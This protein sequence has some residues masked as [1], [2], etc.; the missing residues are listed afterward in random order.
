MSVAK[1]T[2]SAKK[3]SVK[4]PQ[5]SKKAPKGTA[6]RVER[7]LKAVVTK[8]SA[9]PQKI[10][11]PLSKSELAEFRTMLLNKRRSLVGDMNGMQNEALRVNRQDGSGDLSL[12][13]D[14]PANIASDT[15]E[16]EFTLGLLES[17]RTLLN[18]ID[19]ALRRIETGEYGICVGT[20][21]LISKARLRARPW[22]KYCI[23]YAHKIEKGLVRPG[24]ERPTVD[25][26]EDADDSDDNDGESSED[27]E[28]AHEDGDFSDPEA[29]NEE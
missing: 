16:Q 9:K 5:A 4:S 12:M 20:G 13:P 7:R 27:R 14:H 18:E 21:E 22:S 28:T 11:C 1:K 24:D 15:F 8:P 3:S 2:T 6:Q 17:E 29:F 26:D 23:E 19:D 10:K 25:E